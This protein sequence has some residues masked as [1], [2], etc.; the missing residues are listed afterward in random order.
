MP[1]IT[2]DQIAKLRALFAAST[3]VSEPWYVDYMCGNPET[4]EE[5]SHFWIRAGNDQVDDTFITP[6]K[7]DYL[8]K[9]DAEWIV[10]ACL[11]VPGLLD[12]VERLTTERN[13]WHEQSN[14]W[15]AKVKGQG[16]MAAALAEQMPNGLRMTN[17]KLRQKNHALALER[18][19]LRKLAWDA[20]YALAV[21]PAGPMATGNR[22]FVLEVVERLR[23]VRRETEQAPPPAGSQCPRSCRKRT[24]KVNDSFCR[25][26]REEAARRPGRS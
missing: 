19:A 24:N 20:E 8:R 22:D 16:E 3:Q 7:A 14:R 1:S 18:D 15:A 6:L 11:A 21:I 23:K 5:D 9:A 25:A 12:E 13:E 17:Q 10:A 4:G 2:T 26:C